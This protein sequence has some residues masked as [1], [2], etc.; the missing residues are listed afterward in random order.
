VLSVRSQGMAHN[1]C[2]RHLSNSRAVAAAASE[3]L[4][5]KQALYTGHPPCDWMY[6]LQ[7]AKPDTVLWYVTYTGAAKILPQPPSTWTWRVSSSTFWVHQ[8]CDDAAHTAADASRPH[9]VRNTCAA[10]AIAASISTTASQKLHFNHA[11]SSHLLKC[12]DMQCFNCHRSKI[13]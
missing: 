2:M 5:C 7:H 11:E 4:C 9:E 12:F 6:V 3:L 10:K 8:L 1:C 13:A